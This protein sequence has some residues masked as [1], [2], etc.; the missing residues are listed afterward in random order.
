M[1]IDSWEWSKQFIHCQIT[2]FDKSFISRKLAL[3]DDTVEMFMRLR[4]IF[5]HT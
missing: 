1:A 4:I 5:R 2:T 3:R